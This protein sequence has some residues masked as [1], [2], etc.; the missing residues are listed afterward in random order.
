VNRRVGAS[1]FLNGATV[2]QTPKKIKQANPATSS[3]I[4][5]GEFDGTSWTYWIPDRIIAAAA[6]KL[7]MP[8]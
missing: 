2:S 1:G 7:T 4:T 3:P 5:I 6:V 8:T